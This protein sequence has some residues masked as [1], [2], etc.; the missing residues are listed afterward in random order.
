MGVFRR[1]SKL[2]IRVKDKSQ[3]DPKKQW[4][5]EPTKYRVGQ[6][7]LAERHFR[8]TQ[9]LLD[10]GE[11]LADEEVGKPTVRSY[12]A[13]WLAA[14]RERGVE[15]VADEEARLKKWV[16][17]ALGLVSLDE[18]HPHQVQAFVR[19]L[20]TKTSRRKTP[21]APR[22]QR[23]IFRDLKA[24]LQ[25]AVADE[26][27]VAN[28]AVLKRG[29]LPAKRDA[30]PTWREGAVFTH[31]EV[32]RIISDPKVP[33]DRRV[34]YALYFLSGLRSSEGYVL[35]WSDYDT[36]LKPLG[37]LMV[38]KGYSRRRKEEKATKTERPRPVPVH[39][40]LAVVLASWRESGW[41]RLLGREP[42]TEDLIIPSRLGRVRSVSHML[43]KFHQDLARLGLRERRAYDSRR[44]FISLTLGD[45]ARR[46][47]LRWVTHPPREQ[48]DDYTSMPWAALCEAVACLKIPPP[49]GA[50]GGVGAAKAPEAKIRPG[51]K[52]AKS[53]GA[54]EKLVT[55]LVTDAARKRNMPGLLAESG[56]ILAGCT[57]LEAGS[58]ATSR[59]DVR[60]RSNVIP[61]RYARPNVV[62]TTANRAMTQS[63]CNECNEPSAEAAGRAL[64]ALLRGD[65]A[66]ARA[67]LWR[68]SRA[69]PGT[70]T[71]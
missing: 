62:S 26:L 13:R 37:R 70:K 15:T 5:S 10:A 50:P 27:I 41:V 60:G 53:G 49:G 12:G 59:A 40:A 45:G 14:R 21:L 46:D 18:L 71:A 38:S 28:P 9:A 39:P 51:R 20:R 32:V 19:G 52:S 1:G 44:T 33:E 24:L 11:E 43:K 35:R 2:W 8:S 54:S 57:G 42:K 36:T 25:E 61:M 17:P 34:A 65:L 68:L 55:P 23:H 6:E 7:V 4:R 29:D 58:S 56:H 48:F 31:A 69:T 63:A 30:D 67:L 64:A 66:P 3:P 16:Y 47:I 22:T